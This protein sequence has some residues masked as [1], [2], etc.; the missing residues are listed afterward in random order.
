MRDFRYAVRVLLKAPVF[1]AAA[2]ATLALCIGANTAI[3]TVVDHLLL[4]PLPYPQPDRLA[5]V[6]THSERDGGTSDNIGQTGSTWLALRES[7]T[8]GAAAP[9]AP[10]IDV[11]SVGGTMGINIVTHDR[12]EYVMQR[13]VS[14]G[15]FRVLGVPL[16]VG[17]EF[18]A[19]EDTAGGPAAVILSHGLWVRAFGADPGIVGRSIVVRGEPHSVIGVAP[20]VTFGDGRTSGRRCDLAAGGRRSELRFSRLSPAT[21]WAQAVRRSLGRRP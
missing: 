18:S 7:S 14:T 15:F 19:G 11:A 17:R 13:R 3:Y 1:A 12:P 6:V 9:G 5:V 8:G 10:A 4:R 20:A 21:T 2:I 16:A